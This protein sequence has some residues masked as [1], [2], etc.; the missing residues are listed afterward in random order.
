MVADAFSRA[1]VSAPHPL[2]RHSREHSHQVEAGASV[3]N[4]SKGATPDGE[5]KPG[6]PAAGE[7]VY[8]VDPVTSSGI[9]FS[10]QELLKAQQS[11]PFCRRAQDLSSKMSGA[12][13][14]S[15]RTDSWYCSAIAAGTL[16]TY[17]LDADGVLL[18]YIPSEEA[19]QDSFNVGIPCSLRKA[20]LSYFHD[21]WLAGHT[22]MKHDA[23]HYG[24]S[25]RLCQCV[26]PRAGKPPGS[27][28]R[29]TASYAGKLQPVTLWDPFPEA[30]E[31]Y[32]FLLAVTDHFTKCVELFTLRKLTARAI[33]NK[34]TRS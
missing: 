28:N 18:R 15:V 11:D 29:S 9:V 25:C 19:P 14:L 13:K 2:V 6:Y 31:G 17:L 3:S 26:K 1:P 7:D 8:L 32:V 23:L 5:A 33:W 16:D 22:S 24:S 20:T 4:G 12:A 27:C 34:L 21:W 10:R 30:S